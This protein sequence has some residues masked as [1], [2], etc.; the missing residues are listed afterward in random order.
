MIYNKTELL[1]WLS[2]APLCDGKEFHEGKNYDFIHSFGK[3]FEKEYSYSYGATKLVLIPFAEE[4][5]Y[6]IKIPY[7]GTY[8]S[9][10]GY[11]SGSHNQY[12]HR[13]TEYYEDYNYA[14]DGERPWDY[15]A[16][17]VERYIIAEDG[18][19]AP[20]FAKTDLLGFVND[21]PIY[22]QEKC[23]IFSKRRKHSDKENRKTADCCPS[24]YYR[25]NLDWLTDFRLYA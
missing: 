12:Y 16:T 17:E 1:K 5:N 2:Q 4:K 24:S 25:I 15:C 11:F 23:S 22:I 9:Y 8:Y 6:V 7:T 18:G 21:Y 20:Y 3:E 19:F 13:S 10:N 14:N